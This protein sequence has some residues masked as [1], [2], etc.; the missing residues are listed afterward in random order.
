MNQLDLAMAALKM[1]EDD[2]KGIFYLA[3]L[4]GDKTARGRNGQAFQR[5][6]KHNEKARAMCSQLDDALAKEFR[7]KWA[8]KHDFAFVHEEREIRAEYRKE[9][10]DAGKYFTKAQLAVSLGISAYPEGSAER[11]KVTQ[12]V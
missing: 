8:L 2:P 4:K 11:E 6:I 10:T 3:S 7:Q 5:A 12:Q 1:V 9:A